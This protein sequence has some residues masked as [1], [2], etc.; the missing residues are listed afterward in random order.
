MIG[1]ARY[2]EKNRDF[3]TITIYEYYSGLMIRELTKLFLCQPRKKNCIYNSAIFQSSMLF[4][5][6]F[7]SNNILPFSVC[8]DIAIAHRKPSR[9]HFIRKCIC[10]SN[11]TIYFV[12]WGLQNL[13]LHSPGACLCNISL[14]CVAGNLGKRDDGGGSNDLK[15]EVNRETE[16]REIS[17]DWS[18]CS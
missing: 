16:H 15:S 11:G 4:W 17:W 14:Y 8:N 13:K 12:V 9:L 2:W 1:P 5:L 10:V 6:E 7:Y 3:H 18:W